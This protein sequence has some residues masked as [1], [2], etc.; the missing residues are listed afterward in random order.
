MS[1]QNTHEN[2]VSLK[3]TRKKKGRKYLGIAVIFFI[4]YIIMYAVGIEG[5]VIMAFLALAWVICLIGG[6]IYLIAG[7]VGKE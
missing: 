6:L 2:T 7:F 3:E 1:T 4:I 5:G